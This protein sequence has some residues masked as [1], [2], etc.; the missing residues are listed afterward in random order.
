MKS[1]CAVLLAMALFVSTLSCAAQEPIPF[2]ELARSSNAIPSLAEVRADHD[3]QM[4]SSAHIYKRHWSK[5]GKIMTVIGIS[6]MAAGGALLGS[7]L[8]RNCSA[9]NM[10][11]LGDAFVA[12][13]DILLTA[14]GVAV[15]VVGATRR[16]PE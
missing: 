7:T 15:T 11:C 16:T 2:N 8:E 13:G 14:S 10:S 3:A 4:A 9:N 12:T 6:V 5:G 1:I